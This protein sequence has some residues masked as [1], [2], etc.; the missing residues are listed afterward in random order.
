MN[1]YLAV[2]YNSAENDR[3]RARLIPRGKAKRTWIG[4][5]DLNMDGV[6]EAANGRK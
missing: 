6:W 3:I 5:S 1:R 4:V 2:P